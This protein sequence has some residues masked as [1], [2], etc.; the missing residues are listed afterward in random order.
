MRG[1]RIFIKYTCR[2]FNYHFQVVDGSLVVNQMALFNDKAHYSY[3]PGLPDLPI[4]K[5]LGAGS[6][7][8]I[9]QMF[10]LEYNSLSALEK[11]LVLETL[12]KGERILGLGHINKGFK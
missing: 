9:L 8:E 1:K 12:D 2:F 3:V 10:Q 7:E 6:G 4:V 5:V 11:L